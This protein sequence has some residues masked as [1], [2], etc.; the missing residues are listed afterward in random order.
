MAMVIGVDPTRFGR[1]LRG[2]R[3]WSADETAA[4]ARYLEVS[5]AVLFGEEPTPEGWAPS[6]SNRR[7]KD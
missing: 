3:S 5:V 2:E 6:G 7:P 1:R 4:A